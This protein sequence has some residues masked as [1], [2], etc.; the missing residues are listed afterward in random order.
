MPELTKLND[1]KG[2]RVPY[3]RKDEA[4]AEYFSHVLWTNNSE[5]PQK[6]NPPQIVLEDLGIDTGLITDNELD[7]IIK[8]LQN[9]KAPGPDRCTTELFKFK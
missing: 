9:N 3:G 7:N 4:T 6:V 1:I 2:N 5:T 8:R